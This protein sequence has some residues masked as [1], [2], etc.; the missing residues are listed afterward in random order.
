[1]SLPNAA[2][3]RV[4]VSDQ[5]QTLC[6]SSVICVIVTVATRTLPGQFGGLG[7]RDAGDV[8]PVDGQ[9]KVSNHQSCFFSGSV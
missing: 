4:F 3:L 1:M 7:V 8:G 5:S 9:D 2:A 6:G